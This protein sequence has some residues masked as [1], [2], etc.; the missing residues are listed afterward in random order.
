MHGR[1]SSHAFK[2]NTFLIF[3]K[4]LPAAP[5]PSEGISLSPPFV[6]S[7]SVSPSGLFVAGTADGRTWV[8]GGGEKRSDGKKK[9]SRKWEGLR[10]DDG[11]WLQVADGPI[12]GV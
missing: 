4:F 8:G 5:P 1:L 10:E 6:L 7:L 2:R 9:R 12:V 3:H 11:L